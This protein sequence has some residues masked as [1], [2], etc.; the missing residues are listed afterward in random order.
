MIN[1]LGLE[2]D[3]NGI[4]GGSNGTIMRLGD[5]IN[6]AVDRKEKP[7]P[8]ANGM[9]LHHPSHTGWAP[10]VIS[11]FLNHYNPHYL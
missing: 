4:T 1:S 7:I 3:Y 9:V 5:G 6:A 8:I 2:W 11:W 10:P